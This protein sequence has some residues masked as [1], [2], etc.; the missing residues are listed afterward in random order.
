M[1][2]RFML[3]HAASS[4]ILHRMDVEFDGDELRRLEAD[5]EFRAGFEPSVV[6]K[7]RQ[8]MQ[9]VRAASDERDFYALKSLHFEKLKGERSHQRSMRLTKKWRLIVE[10]VG[11]GERKT[12]RV[13]SIED[14]H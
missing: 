11:E 5:E 4:G 3:H 13:V 2:Q 10:L 14:Y 7:F 12:V 8:R 1:I 9:L 6:R